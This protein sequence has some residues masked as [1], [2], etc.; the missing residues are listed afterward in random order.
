MGALHVTRGSPAAENGTGVQPSTA[1]PPRSPTVPATGP[2]APTPHTARTE[3][4]P[5]PRPRLWAAL[6]GVPAMAVLVIASVLWLR[7]GIDVPTAAGCHLDTTS[8]SCTIQ[9]TVRSTGLGGLSYAR[10]SIAQP[11]DADTAL[12][13][14]DDA[15]C[16][17]ATDAMTCHIT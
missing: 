3:T 14:L 1:F 17:S 16:R 15:G 11:P 8:R 2:A 13:A 7:P 6:I 10:A 12:W 4:T 9:V 5:R